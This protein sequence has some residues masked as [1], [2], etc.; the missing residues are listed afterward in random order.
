MIVLLRDEFFDKICFSPNST[1]QGQLMC[2]A[3]IIGLSSREIA[4]NVWIFILITG[5]KVKEIKNLEAGKHTINLL[6]QPKGL[7][8]VRFFSDG[9]QTRTIEAKKVDSAN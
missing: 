9:D 7:Y 3:A 5:Q 1:L 4:P 2:S 8:L 6:E